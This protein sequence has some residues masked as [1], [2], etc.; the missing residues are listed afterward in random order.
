M[1]DVAWCVRSPTGW[2]KK[3]EG[4]LICGLSGQQ[5]AEERPKIKGIEG[6]G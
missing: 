1:V 4:G 5:K 2:G 3:E 6:Y